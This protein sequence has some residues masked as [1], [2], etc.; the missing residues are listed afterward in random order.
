VYYIINGLSSSIPFVGLGGGVASMY[1][2]GEYVKEIINFVIGPRSQERNIDTERVSF[3]TSLFPHTKGISKRS[4]HGSC[5]PFLCLVFIPKPILSFVSQRKHR[6]RS[7]LMQSRVHLQ[8]PHRLR[9][10]LYS[11]FPLSCIR[12]L[13]CQYLVQSPQRRIWIEAVVFRLLPR[14]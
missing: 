13:F 10:S 12:S 9:V 14:T 8:I 4:F 5:T 6:K 3:N 2:A 1:E 11:L 7:T